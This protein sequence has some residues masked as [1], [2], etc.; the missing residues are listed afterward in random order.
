MSNAALIHALT[1]SLNRAKEPALREKLA[2]MI[3]QLR[4]KENRSNGDA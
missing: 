2:A 3:E 4:A 1:A